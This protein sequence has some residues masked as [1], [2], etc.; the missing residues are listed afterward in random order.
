MGVVDIS[1][2]LNEDTKKEVEVINLL[3]TEAQLKEIIDN[4]HKFM[5]GSLANTMDVPV[6]IAKRSVLIDFPFMSKL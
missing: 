3:S 4:T 1:M 5:K 2:R 6:E